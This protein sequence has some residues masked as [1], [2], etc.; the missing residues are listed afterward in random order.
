MR[1][2]TFRQQCI[3]LNQTISDNDFTYGLKEY[4]RKEAIGRLF[5]AHPLVSKS[6]AYCSH[7]G[8]EVHVLTQ[9][10]CPVC[11]KKWGKAEK[12]ERASRH[13]E[14]EYLCV[15]TVMEGLQVMRFWCFEYYFK[16]GRQTDYFVKEV[17]RQFIRDDGERKGFA[18]SRP[19][20][21][22]GCYDAWNFSSQITIR[23]TEPR[24][25]GYYGDTTTPRFD[26]PCEMTVIKQTI[27]MLR[28]NGLRRSMHGVWYPTGI[29]LGLLRKPQ[30]ESL[31]KTGQYDLAVYSA[32]NYRLA[33]EDMASVR[34]CHRNHYRV[35]DVRMWLDHLQTLR[36]L[37][38][39]THNAK[40][41]C[42]KNLRKAH[43]EMTK[44][45]NRQ[46]E[47]AEAERRAK[48]YA[49]QLKRMEKDRA[50]YVKRLGDLLTI[51]LKGRNLSIRPLQS[52]DEFAEE[53]K[54][55]HHC[56][57]ANGYYKQ[58]NTLILSAKDGK[59]NRLATIEY[60]TKRYAI[61]QC[62]AA[63]NA[64]PKR[65]TEIRTLITSHRQ[66]FER[67]MKAA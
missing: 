58:P 37:G 3:R 12:V 41:V 43:E 7:C 31:W 54:A 66:D 6:K 4:E 16:V 27:P 1:Q 29:V 45:L 18:L 61:E 39:D 25:W 19:M 63:C 57:F 28:R 60:N 22:G 50:D 51:A 21:T 53:G 67:L 59:G 13:R 56:V 14:R 65:D 34:I 36:S 24:Y 17:E 23:D 35:K 40:Y 8:S 49:E 38:L 20:M 62:R 26:L 9:Q 44:R 52:V 5:P 30:V 46:R 33:D 15:M 47:K 32:E 2:E 48:Q 64:V 10:E 55:M 42:P 11:H